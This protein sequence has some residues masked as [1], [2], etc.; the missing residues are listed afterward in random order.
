MQQLPARPF[1][2]CTAQ[3]GIVRAVLPWNESANRAVVIML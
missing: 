3:T 1:L 2:E